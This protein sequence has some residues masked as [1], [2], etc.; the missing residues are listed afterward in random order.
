MNPSGK[1]ARGSPLSAENN[2]MRPTHL[3]TRRRRYFVFDDP[4]APFFPADDV[5]VKAQSHN[6]FLTQSTLHGFKTIDAA[7][8]RGGEIHIT[9][10]TNDG[11]SPGPLFFYPFFGEPANLHPLKHTTFFV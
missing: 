8:G 7:I 2:S 1:I 6:L 9:S 11:G 3:F 5:G 10:R 4:P